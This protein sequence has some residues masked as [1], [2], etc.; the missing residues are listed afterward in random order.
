MQ[1]TTLPSHKTMLASAMLLALSAPAM[2]SQFSAMRTAETIQLRDT[3]PVRQASLSTQ[4][5]DGWLI[6]LHAPPLSQQGDWPA[7]QRQQAAANIQQ[8]QQDVMQLIARHDRDA[9]LHTTTEILAA[10]LVVSANAAAIEAASQSSQVAKV[11]PLFHAKPHAVDSA[12]AIGASQLV[13]AG[14]ATGRDIR[15]AVLD[16]GIDYTHQLLGGDGTEQAYL[17]AISHQNE[18]AWPIGSVIG[19]F[20]FME[21]HPN[22]IDTSG[23]GTPVAHAVLAAAP[24]AE[25]Y[26]FTVCDTVCPFAAQ[27][28]GIEAAMDPTG[29]G[30]LTNRADIIN[31]SLGGQFGST[32]TVSGTQYLL[33]RAA[34]LGV[35]VVASAGN[36]GNV[37]FRI[38]G[39]STTPNAL[40]VGAMTHPTRLSQVLVDS[41]LMGADVVAEL[42]AFNPAADFSFN[43]SNA[44]FTLIPDNLL[45][46]DPVDETLD[47]T[48]QAVLVFRGDCPFSQKVLNAQA[49]G[50]SLVVIANNLPGDPPFSAGG[51]NEGITIPSLMITLE[52]GIAIQSSILDGLQVDYS[53]RAEQRALSGAVANFSSR[54]PAMDGLLKP[55]ITAPGEGIELAAMGTRDGV[56][57]FSGT[58]FSAPLVSGAA[59]LLREIHPERTAFE[60]KA[61]LM[62]TADLEVSYRPRAQDENAPGAPVSLIGAGMINVEKAAAS[63]VA[64]WV[65]DSR[66]QTRQAAL[67]FGLQPM[68]RTTTLVKQVTLKNFDSHAR[69]YQLQIAPR[70][71]NKPGADALSWD[72]PATVQV[73]PL[74]SVQFEVA[75]TVNPGKLPEFGLFNMVRDPAAALDAIEFDG[76]LLFQ[77]PSTGHPHDLHLVYHIIPKA[78]ADM[79]I[80]TEITDQG[81]VLTL[82]N[83]GITELAP[84]A[85]NLVVSRQSPL[86]S[87]QGIN[88]ISLHVEEDDWCSSGYSIYPSFH[89]AGNLNH[90]LQNHVG[91]DLDVTGDGFY[92]YSMMSLLVSRLGPD[93]ASLPGV[94]VTFTTAFGQL[95]GQ[96]GDLYH[97]SGQNTVTLQ[98]CL[99]DIGLGVQDIGSTINARFRTDSNGLSLGP[100]FGGQIADQVSA[101]VRIQHAPS[102]SLTDGNG[103]SIGPLQPGERGYLQL[104]QVTAPGFVLI[105]SRGDAVVTADLTAALQAPRLQQQNFAIEENT[106][107]GTW[108]G[109]LQADVDFRA[110]VAEF[111]LVQSSSNAIS[112]AR[113]GSLTVHNSAAL[114]Y[115]A[116][117]RHIQLSVLVIDSLG[118]V[119][120]AQPINIKVTNVPDEPPTVS[121]S[122]S[123]ASVAV[124]AASGTVLSS[125][126][127]EV[128]EAYASLASVQT[129]HP[130]FTVQ[131][132]QLQLARSPL[133]ADAGSHQV[134][135]T[136]TDSS[137]LQGQ[138]TVT[139][140]VTRNSAGSAGWYSLLLLPL[141][142]LRRRR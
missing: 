72:Y 79:Q 51:S 39:P 124:G 74:Q 109:T 47:L 90:L 73:G 138:T 103:D 43:S 107:D 54:G 133:R 100:L 3:V 115:E 83:S 139:V 86:S 114:D 123:R 46:C 85:S 56:S 97:F 4:Q 45:A 75:L 29:S 70:D 78:S 1:K 91:I 105:D 9:V 7:Q 18:P 65:N 49:R 64:A 99:E 117:L 34:D 104:E 42:S 96:L 112:L 16:S 71:A 140:E 10:G 60:I 81:P 121:A 113:D 93:F 127:V 59:A 101:R 8:V 136:A 68:Q 108:I 61:T 17:D 41:S 129:A 25:L 19:G 28:G 62:N 55:E 30:T 66:Y 102:L 137:G 87:A 50:A 132:Q 57:R 27:I 14:T 11:L 76:A 106:P 92:D 13:Q 80:G 44:P 48:D 135:I 22:P 32:Q 5:A 21:G 142:W 63:P 122:P 37:P 12:A 128:R 111:V 52:D 131:N 15:I 36:D 120:E 38:A 6:V 130:L 23:H 125:L 89:L 31:L 26:A 77:D 126:Q 134:V 95:S 110:A 20:N 53:F 24:D 67:A 119:S 2:A 118:Q 58:S 82:H 141:L 40:S 94:M 35:L 33:Q 69:S 84:V 98:A 88:S 116:G